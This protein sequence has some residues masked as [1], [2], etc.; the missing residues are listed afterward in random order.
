[1]SKACGL[2][3]GLPLGC[4]KLAKAL[5]LGLTSWAN[6]L[7]LPRGRGSGVSWN[8]TDAQGSRRFEHSPQTN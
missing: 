8:F 4:A 6:A 5:P 3:N 2:A 7:Q 1:M